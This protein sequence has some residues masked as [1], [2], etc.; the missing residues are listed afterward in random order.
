MSELPTT[1]KACVYDQPGK[2]STKI[3]DLN[4]PEPG[5]GEVLIKL[6]VLLDTD[7]TSKHAELE[8]AF[9]VPIPEYA[10]PILPS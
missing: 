7:Q 2:I 1:Y 9:A 6:S 4:M 3:V 10:T 5:H 8:C